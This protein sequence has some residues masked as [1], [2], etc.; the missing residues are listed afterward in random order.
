VSLIQWQLNL[1]AHG[2]DL[3][4]E[5]VACMDDL[6]TRNQG[7]ATMSKDDLATVGKCASNPYRFFN[8]DFHDRIR[9]LGY[10]AVRQIVRNSFGDFTQ[11]GAPYPLGNDM[12]QDLGPDDRVLWLAAYY[13][14]HGH[15]FSNAQH[16][17]LPVAR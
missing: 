13:I 15:P 17:S 1:H 12:G 16:A 7:V 3:Y 6:F 14:N 10:N 11:R 4:G 9:T 5:D 2:A 8:I